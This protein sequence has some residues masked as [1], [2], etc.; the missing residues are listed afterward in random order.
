MKLQDSFETLRSLNLPKSDFAIFGSGPLLVR[1]I[2]AESNDLDV[3]CRGEAWQLVQTLGEKNHLDRYDVTVVIMNGGELSFGDR[4]AI[5]DFD[6]DV[7]IGTAELIDELPFV[8]LEH[9]IRY[10]QMADRDK[11]RAHLAAY[12]AWKRSGGTKLP[13]KGL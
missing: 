6:V 1:G 9:V 7:L 12:E 2:I 8:R 10:K 13:E 4:W 11:D 5:G 3:L